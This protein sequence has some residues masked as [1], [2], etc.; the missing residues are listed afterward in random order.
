M[1]YVALT[2]SSKRTDLSAV[3]YQFL[4]TLCNIVPHCYQLFQGPLELRDLMLLMLAFS[5][6]YSLVLFSCHYT[7]QIKMEILAPN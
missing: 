7:F 3:Q 4:A 2:M 1:L 6:E 5:T